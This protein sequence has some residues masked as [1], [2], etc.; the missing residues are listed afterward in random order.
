MRIKASLLCY[1]RSCIKDY[2]WIYLN[3]NLNPKDIENIIND[4][5]TFDK[6]K[7]N[8]LNHNHLIVR[9]ISNGLAI[10]KFLKRTEVD[11]NNRDIY[12]L[13]G[14]TL[15]D[16]SAFN[17]CS[18]FS[19]AVI[20]CF[21]S[22][23]FKINAIYDKQNNIDYELE[24]PIDSILE[25]QNANTIFV[26]NFRNQID[27]FLLTTECLNGFSIIDKD[28]MDIQILETYNKVEPENEQPVNKKKRFWNKN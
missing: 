3:K 28:F 10:Y 14:F 9:F 4:Y 15:H 21:K 27:T 8:F 23:P 25:T 24:Y 6:N 26:G 13:E 18:I 5:R 12:S 7:A 22:L 1:S 17:W 2:R 19:L 11:C 16:L 20:D